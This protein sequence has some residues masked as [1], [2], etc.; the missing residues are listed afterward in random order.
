M[1]SI[2]RAEIDWLVNLTTEDFVGE[3]QKTANEDRR[4]KLSKGENEENKPL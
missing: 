4:K 3:N 2:N 1:P